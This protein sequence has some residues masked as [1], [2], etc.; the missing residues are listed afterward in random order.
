MSCFFLQK[1]YFVLKSFGYA[2]L[3][4]GKQKIMNL[5]ENSLLSGKTTSITEKI[6]L[7]HYFQIMWITCDNYDTIY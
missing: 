7:T 6:Y 5:I 3:D 2:T 4:R 1:S